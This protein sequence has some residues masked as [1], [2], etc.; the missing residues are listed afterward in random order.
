MFS[1]LLEI[2]KVMLVVTFPKGWLSDKTFYFGILNVGIPE[3]IYIVAKKENL[4]KSG[5]EINETL[6]GGRIRI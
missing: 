2:L 1:K 6:I 3:F 4:F 5:N